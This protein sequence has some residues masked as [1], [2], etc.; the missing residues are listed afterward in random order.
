VP[1]RNPASAAS[2]SAS[3]S[4]AGGSGLL[5]LADTPV[6]A[7][8]FYVD[9]GHSAESICSKEIWVGGQNLLLRA[10]YIIE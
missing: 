9:H 10:T 6:A 2:A 5:H 1:H 3:A 4:A 7:E 8:E